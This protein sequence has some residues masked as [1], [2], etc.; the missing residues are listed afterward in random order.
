MAVT[1]SFPLAPSCWNGKSRASST[2]AGA[3]VLYSTARNSSSRSVLYPTSW[4][5]AV[6]AKYLI[7]AV[8]GEAGVLLTTGTLLHHTWY[9]Y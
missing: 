1:V 3:H 9:Y 2:Q 4:L 7:P 6:L 8:A 5:W